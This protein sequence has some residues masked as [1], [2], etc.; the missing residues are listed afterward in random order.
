MEVH[1][2]AESQH[3]HTALE[4]ESL[5][6]KAKIFDLELRRVSPIGS[7]ELDCGRANTPN[8][9]PL[10]WCFSNELDVASLVTYFD[11]ASN[12]SIIGCHDSKFN[13][14]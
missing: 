13:L 12:F 8:N 6:P 9:C 14:N 4:R 11:A 10:D 2:L 1:R 7:S 5:H 3:K